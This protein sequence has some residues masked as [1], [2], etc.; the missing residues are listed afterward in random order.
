MT[1]PA[2]STVACSLTG[3]AD[4]LAKLAPSH[5]DPERYHAEKSELVHELHKLASALNVN[6][7]V[8][9]HHLIIDPRQ[10]RAAS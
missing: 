10:R 6:D 4:R 7:G 9:K 3:I 1:S 5:R 8:A 2:A